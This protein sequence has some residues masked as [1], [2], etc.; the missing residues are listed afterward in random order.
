MNTAII[1]DIQR[2]SYVDGPGIRTTVFF[3]GCN[4]KCEWCHNPEGQSKNKQILFYKDK[5]TGCGKCKQLCPNHFENC[6]LCGKCALYCPNNAKEIC[7]REYTLD[8]VLHEILKDK[9]FFNASDGGVT[10]SGGECM[11]QVEFL[12]EIL[13]KCKENGVHTAVDTAGNVPWKY[14]E[15]IISYTDLFLYDVKCISDDLHKEGTGESNSLIL[16]NLRKLKEKN[17]EIIVRI[18]VIPEFNGSDYEMQK[19]AEF[20]NQLSINKVELLPYHAMGEHKWIAIGKELKKFSIPSKADIDKF[21]KR[22][23][24]RALRRYTCKHP[25]RSKVGN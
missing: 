25:P 14:F 6:D 4:L 24:A 22:F 5:C 9:E 23:S 7:G 8:E 13:R 21:K 10:F 15:T 18:P 12:L 20:L 11:L 19:I 17:A 1:F 2:G 3:K 16:E